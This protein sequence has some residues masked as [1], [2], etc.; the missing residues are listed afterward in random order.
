[1]HAVILAAGYATR[2]YPYTRNY[3]KALLKIS[4]RPL[5]EHVLGA[6]LAVQAVDGATI[7][8]NDRFYPIFNRWHR[9]WTAKPAHSGSEAAGKNVVL[10][11]DGTRTNE[12]RLGSI[13]DLYFAV[14][15]RRIEDDLLVLCSD[16]VF[17]FSL[18]EMVACADRRQAAVNAVSD[19]GDPGRIKGR[20]GCV[21][22]GRDDRII[23]FQ[24]KPDHPA[25]SIG[26]VAFYV[27]PHRI[28][29]LLEEYC[30]G[31]RARSKNDAEG[32]PA[33]GLGPDRCRARFPGGIPDAPG[34]F[35]QWLCRREPVYAW[36]MD[37]QCLDVGDPASYRACNRRHCARFRDTRVLVVARRPPEGSLP[38][39]LEYVLNR[40]AGWS[41]VTLVYVA[42][43]ERW[44]TRYEAWLTGYPSP[45]P[46]NVV[47]LS[48]RELSEG[49]SREALHVKLGSTVEIDLEQRVRQ[50][51]F[52]YER[53]DDCLQGGESGDAGE[54]HRGVRIRIEAGRITVLT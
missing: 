35:V 52:D 32:E 20:S 27:Y 42:V 24:E 3:P 12:E 49:R 39:D 33:G 18:D 23:D 19:L 17:S 44:S 11:N 29:P 46:V 45:L 30:A 48:A 4:G 25:S 53:L 15:E 41:S 22:L 31:G 14:R 38:A 37:G 9:E 5:L 2:L 1:M 51:D 36:F 16:R 43:D 34:L 13:G 6:A 26:S 40:L 47:A 7:V 54:A 50:I 21:V 8:T 10:L 28:V